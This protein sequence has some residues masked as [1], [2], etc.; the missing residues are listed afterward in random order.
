M[1]I[2]DERKITCK[3]CKYLEIDHCKRFNILNL[4]PDMYRCSDFEHKDIIR[5]ETYE[6]KN[7]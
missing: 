4:K 6:N 3:Y 7:K 2:L 5:D 1:S